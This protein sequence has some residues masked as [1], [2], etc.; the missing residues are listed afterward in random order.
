MRKIVLTFIL[1]FSLF[2]N[3]VFA[4]VDVNLS[5]D[6]QKLD[7]NDNLSLSLSVSS[8][9]AESIN[10][11]EIFWIENFD[12]V[13]QSKTSSYQNINW[14]TSIITNFN[15]VLKPKDN[16]T[17]YLWPVKVIVDSEEKEFWEVKNIEVTWDKLFIWNSPDLSGFQIN[18]GEETWWTDT[19]IS[20]V[21]NLSQADIANKDS[22]KQQNESWTIDRVKDLEGNEMK[23]IYDIKKNLFWSPINLVWSL[24]Y[25][26]FFIVAYYLYKLYL[27]SRDK[28]EQVISKPEIVEKKE[29]NYSKLLLEI[30]EKY[31]WE[32]KEIFYAKLSEVVRL[33]L[34]DKI[35]NW[36][37]TKTLKEIK[38]KVSFDLQAIIE[39]VYFPEYDD[40]DDSL[41]QREEVLKQTKKLF[42]K[43]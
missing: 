22:S 4:S 15:L 35:A 23:D 3:F 40:K 5:V 33:Y 13:W 28:L 14:K 31:I 38:W 21:Q 9:D 10:I 2:F 18:N 27:K 36:L 12:I 19:W 16:W 42:L 26:L 24:F 11:D 32:T 43:P 39:K 20:N 6:K 29:I 17:Y 41:E 34:D 1:Y 30:E 25:I 8:D 37:S 7:I